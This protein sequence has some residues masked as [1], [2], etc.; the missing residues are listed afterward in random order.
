MERGKK[1]DPVIL[2]QGEVYRAEGTGEGPQTSQGT[3]T[4]TSQ[5][6]AGTRGHGESPRLN[7]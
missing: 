4:S 2:V 3:E 5:G 6:L 7:R 1:R